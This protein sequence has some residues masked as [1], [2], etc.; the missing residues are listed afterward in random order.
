[1]F[2]NNHAYINQS[3]HEAKNNP[4]TVALDSN[5]QTVLIKWI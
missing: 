3:D 2:D 5:K 4:F 1:M